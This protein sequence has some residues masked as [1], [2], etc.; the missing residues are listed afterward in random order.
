MAP[1]RR[2][3]LILPVKIAV[4]LILLSDIISQQLAAKLPWGHIMVLI[5][6]LKPENERMRNIVNSA[7]QPEGYA[8]RSAGATAR[9][10]QS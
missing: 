6:R 10:A 4:N 1:V 9:P 7:M 3:V 8:E 2:S 5:D